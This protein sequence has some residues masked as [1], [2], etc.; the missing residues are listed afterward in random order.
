MNA[1]LW[2]PIT[3][4]VAFWAT[5]ATIGALVTDIGPWYKSL[6]QPSW[7]PADKYFGLI[8][9]TVFICA[10]TGGVVAWRGGGTQTERTLFL[11]AC[12][13]NGLGNIHWSYLFFRKRRPDW[14]QLQV[15]PFYAS[16]WWM[17]WTAYTL[18]PDAGIWF[19]PYI[20][21]VTAAIK[22]NWDVVQLNRPF[23]G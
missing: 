3:G 15:L 13:V 20:L 14:A 4:A 5:V 7:K 23:S 11:V 6:R 22:L 9:T 17:A 19:V 2:G 18:T 12:V 1:S 21:W 10:G 8:W 16:I